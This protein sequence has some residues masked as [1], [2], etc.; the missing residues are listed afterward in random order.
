MSRLE[1]K[2]TCLDGYYHLSCDIEDKL[3]FA[4]ETTIASLTSKTGELEAGEF[5]DKLNKADLRSWDR[6]YNAT[7]LK[8]EDATRWSVKYID[9]SETYESEG[10]ESYE[11]YKY[12][13]L[14]DALCVLDEKAKYL[15]FED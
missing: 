8:I 3:V 7:S 10:E 14:I 13:D 9:G 2:F 15:K 11:P 12:F 6:Y 1:Y 4:V 5:I